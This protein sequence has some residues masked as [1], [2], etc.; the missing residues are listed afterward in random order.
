[1]WLSSGL[2][3]TLLL[4]PLI[5]IHSKNVVYRFEGRTHTNEFHKSIFTSLTADN[6][7]GN[8][9]VSLLQLQTH[10][11]FGEA[12]SKKRGVCAHSENMYNCS[13]MSIVGY[14]LY[15]LLILWFQNYFQNTHTHVIFPNQ[16][17]K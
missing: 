16:P 14:E 11:K 4:L 10:C 9:D 15:V 6:L 7:K 17:L 8:Q 5:N 12:C 2:A 13:K 3:L 1:M